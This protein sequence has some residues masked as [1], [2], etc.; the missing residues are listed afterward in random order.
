M[1][2]R[3]VDLHC[4]KNYESMPRMDLPPYKPAKVV[5]VTPLE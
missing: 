3:G 4:D 1:D 5:I 2:V